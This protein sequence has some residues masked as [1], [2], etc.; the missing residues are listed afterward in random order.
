MMEKQ[1]K[2]QKKSLRSIFCILEEVESE[3]ED[4]KTGKHRSS[5]Y[6][7]EGRNQNKIRL[8]PK[9]TTNKNLKQCH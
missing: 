9:W 5:C 3:K 2:I 7:R 4:G 8:L 1:L 6:V